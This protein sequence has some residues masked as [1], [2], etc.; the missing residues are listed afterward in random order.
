MATKFVATAIALA[1]CINLKEIT[2]NYYY[3][4]PSDLSIKTKEHKTMPCSFPNEIYL[5]WIHKTLLD[6]PNSLSMRTRFA[7]VSFRP[8]N[9]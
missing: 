4:Y 5:R 3:S 8:G 9:R 1:V 2:V 7:T 6:A